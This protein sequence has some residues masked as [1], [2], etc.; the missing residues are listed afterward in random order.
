[1]INKL[2]MSGISLCPFCWWKQILV[3]FCWCC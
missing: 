1:M 3:H 2:M